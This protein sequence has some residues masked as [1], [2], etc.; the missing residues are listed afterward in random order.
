MKTFVY[1]ILLTYS[2]GYCLGQAPTDKLPLMDPSGPLPQALTSAEM[3]KLT[4]SVDRGLRALSKLQLADG[5]FPTLNHGKPAITSFAIMAYLSR[6][7]RPGEGPYGK[8]IDKALDYVLTTQKKSGLFAS[9]E[10]NTA[11][12]NV[13]IREADV[14]GAG[15]TAKTYNHAICMLMLGEVYGLTDPKHTFRVKAAITKGLKFT[16]ELW[17]I[18]KKSSM[19][20]GGFRYTRLH[21]SNDSDL[22]VTAWHVSSLRSIRNA[23]FDVPENVMNRI[24]AYVVKTQCPDG[25]FSYLVRGQ[26][27]FVMT[28]AGTLCIGLAARHDHSSLERACRY[29]YR[30]NAASPL[31]FKATGG[32]TI[33]AYYSCYYV[34]QAAIQ[35]GGALWV[36]CM[37][38]CYNYLLPKQLASGHWPAFERSA[39][40]GQAYS[41]SLAI[42]ALTPSMQI[43]PIYQR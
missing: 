6:G 18:R 9:Q 1:I 2:S 11:L 7:H 42:I 43:L 28:A 30:F 27:S 41:T 17:D 26:S 29:L 39:R 33:Y 16:L 31:C 35:M 20:D 40:Y 3:Q 10:I 22:S 4:T 32:H 37:K 13:P 21:G 8:Q 25:G 38:E 12:I 5:S 14:R 34:T 23:G 24:V 15:G 36:K 19:N